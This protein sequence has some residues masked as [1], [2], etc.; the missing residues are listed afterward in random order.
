[1]ESKDRRSSKEEFDKRRKGDVAVKN[2]RDKKERGKGGNEGER[3]EL[4]RVHKVRCRDYHL[5]VV[6]RNL[7]SY[8][9]R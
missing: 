4:N 2:V 6:S 7:A 8:E 1:M 9:I 5:R 3:G